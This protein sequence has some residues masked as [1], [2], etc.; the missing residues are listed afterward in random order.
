VSVADV[1]VVG[2][3]GPEAMATDGG[4]T[5]WVAVVVVHEAAA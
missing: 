4:G 3:T 2:L 1:E 5:T